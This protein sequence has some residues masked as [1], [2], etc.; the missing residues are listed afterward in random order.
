MEMLLFL[1]QLEEKNDAEKEKHFKDRLFSLK[2]YDNLQKGLRFK[3]YEVIGGYKQFKQDLTKVRQNYEKALSDF[4]QEEIELVWSSFANQ[5][6]PV[7][8][9][10]L[11]KD[12]SLSEI[13]KK[14]E[15]DENAKLMKQR[16]EEMAIETQKALDK[17]KKELLDEQERLRAERERQ[18]KKGEQKLHEKLINIASLA[19]NK[20]DET[21]TL[22]QIAALEKER[23]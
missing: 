8:T 16:E 1:S 3:R 11:K 2:S 10:I 12:N 22:N 5:L 20:E 15:K 17:Q 19:E 4:Q 21:N 23:R 7:E 14:K 13:E 9:E 6:V 18:Y